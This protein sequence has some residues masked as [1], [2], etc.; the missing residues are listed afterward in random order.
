MARPGSADLDVDAVLLYI[1][2][3]TPASEIRVIPMSADRLAPLH[4]GEV[5]SAEFMEPLGLS[6][7]ALAARIR[8][9]ANRI[10]TIVK[11]QRGITGDT[12]RRLGRVFGTSAEF[13]MNLQLRYDLERAEDAAGADF[14]AI[15][16][17]SEAELQAA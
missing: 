13:W 2:R 1:P 7:R 12:A 11:G 14:E 16:P 4:P 6:S 15:R 17:F 10:S 3:T 8:V 5:L 9:P